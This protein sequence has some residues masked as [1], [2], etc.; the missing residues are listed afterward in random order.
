MKFIFLDTLNIN[1]N[2][3][4]PEEGAAE[5]FEITIILDAYKVQYLKVKY[6]VNVTTFFLLLVYS[7]EQV[8]GQVS[9]RR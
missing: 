7:L 8:G 5:R 4:L 6:L 2:R 3:D 1:L 9:V